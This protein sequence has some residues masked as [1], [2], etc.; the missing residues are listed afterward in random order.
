M[1][2]INHIKKELFDKNDTST[3]N[4]PPSSDARVGHSG[5]WNSGGYIEEEYNPKLDQDL[6]LGTFFDAGIVDKMRK[7]DA[8]INAVLLIHN[9]ALQSAKYGFLPASESE[10]DIEIANFVTHNYFE[11]QSWNNIIEHI[12]LEL[13]FGFSVFETFLFNDTWKKERWT[14]QL[15]EP[16]LPKTIKMWH[17]IN[18]RL[19]H[20]TQE[21][22]HGNHEIPASKTVIFSYK[23][24]G[25]NYE[26]ISVLR[27]VYKNWKMKDS[28]QKM[29]AVGIEKA[30]VPFLHME[31][32]YG[33][34]EEETSRANKFA[35]NFRA[36][37]KLYYISQKK[38]LDKETGWDVNFV[39]MKDIM[40]DVSA[41]IIHHDQQIARNLGVDMIYTS[42]AK[43]SSAVLNESVK[44][45]FLTGLQSIANQIEDIFNRGIVGEF[46][47]PIKRLVDLNFGKQ[48]QY[49]KLFISNLSSKSP[50]NLL[51]Q[52]EM[53]KTLREGKIDVTTENYFRKMSEIPALN[54]KEALE[55]QKQRE[56]ENKNGE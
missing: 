50:N 4:P 26:G 35:D 32:P 10:K 41:A 40:V 9:R 24:E 44:D 3:G 31:A 13:P 29:Q 53:L 54:D 20:I 25:N 12:M 38:G 15:L 52:S 21:T 7:S 49:P 6:W 1:A 23:R 55:L 2:I 45:T 22:D 43:R 16:R 46:E 56:M 34:T 33:A 37:E 51:K 14:F 19:N 42:E 48:D 28:F 18:G 39:P 8:Q 5:T 17:E 36:N 47:S 30:S 27:N 11:V